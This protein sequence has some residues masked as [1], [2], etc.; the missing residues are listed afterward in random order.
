[1][2]QWST[3]VDEWSECLLKWVR[4]GAVLHHLESEYTKEKNV[5]DK[6]CGYYKSILP[7]LSYKQSKT[8]GLGKPVESK[9]IILWYL[10]VRSS[11]TKKVF[12]QIT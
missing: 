5:S 3:Q 12:K 11:I 4:F 7:T 1:M 6:L 2:V 9:L 10:L 8:L